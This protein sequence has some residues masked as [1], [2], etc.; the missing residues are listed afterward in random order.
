MNDHYMNESHQIITRSKDIFFNSD[1]N[2]NGIV[3][4]R[5]A[6]GKEFQTVWLQKNNNL[7]RL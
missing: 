3:I 2:Y 4:C 6:N 5:K 7:F 1:L